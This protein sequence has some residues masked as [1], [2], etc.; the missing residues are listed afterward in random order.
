M[1]GR[2][3]TLYTRQLCGLCDAAAAELRHLAGPLSFSLVEFDIDEDAELRAQYNDIV[4]VI[5][6]AGSVIAHAPVDLA[7]LRAA[8]AEALAR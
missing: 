4:P 2:Q 6:V 7:E 3:V 5:A 8:L 1:T